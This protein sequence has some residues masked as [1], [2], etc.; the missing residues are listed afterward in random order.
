LLF[1]LAAHP[2]AA[3]SKKYGTFNDHPQTEWLDVA[4]A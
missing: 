4:G 3:Q 2:A 1:A